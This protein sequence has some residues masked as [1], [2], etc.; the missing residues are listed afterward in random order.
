MKHRK[1][2][3]AALSLALALLLPLA[4]LA[5]EYV[6]ED[7][8]LEIP[9]DIYVF[10]G[11]TPINSPSWQLAGVED[12]N[13][14]MSLYKSSNSGIMG[15]FGGSAQQNMNALASFIGH[16]GAVDVTLSRKISAESA[17]IH[18][19][20]ELSPE[21][22][23]EFVNSL[24][25]D[26]EEQDD[27]GLGESS[28]SGEDELSQVEVN[29]RGELC[30]DFETPFGII[31]FYGKD[32]EQQDFH[33]RVYVT[34]LNGSAVSMHIYAV[35]EE[36]AQ[37]AVAVQNE[38]AASFKISNLIDQAQAA[39]MSRGKLTMLI[40]LLIMITVS[41]VGTIAFGRHRRKKDKRL[42][43][44]MA[45]KLSKYRALSAEQDIKGKLC[46]ANVTDCSDAVIRRFSIYHSYLKNL[47]TLIFGVVMCVLLVVIALI[48]SNEW[49]TTLISFALAGYYIFKLI[50]SSAN[51]ERAQKKAYG[52]GNSSMA[53]YAFYEN[54][55]RVSGIQHV[56]SYPY[57]QITEIKQDKEYFYL[58]YGPENAYIVSK[59]G[60]ANGSAEEFNA[61]ISEKEK[62]G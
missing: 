26:I 51:F 35:G 25:G 52:A 43:Q 59:N 56:A 34:I 50:S 8:S 33:E 61:F 60:F 28:T 45:E 30:L 62:E 31:D 46:F 54:A 24:L 32:D 58:Y 3:A 40:V 16:G 49:F 37:E 12:P 14:V 17:Q 29:A 9:E 48:Y 13:Q 20:S 22:Q 47:P 18:N 7:F 36:L 53:K 4:A 6:Q 55:F 5:E 27:T 44:E 15:I 2:I 42:K 1:I 19:L 11:Q 10:D 21:Q 41:I 23:Q 38:L 39:E 57:F